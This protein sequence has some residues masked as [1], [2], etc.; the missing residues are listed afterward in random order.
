MGVVV[1]KWINQR[2]IDDSPIFMKFGDLKDKVIPIIMPINNVIMM[3]DLNRL[4][5]IK[6]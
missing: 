5:K 4:G 6:I 1:R 3:K 2:L